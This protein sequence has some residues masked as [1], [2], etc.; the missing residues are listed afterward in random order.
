AALG[1]GVGP[2]A[3]PLAFAAPLFLSATLLFLV[4]P[5][6]AKMVLPLLGGAPAVWNTCMV[7]YQAALLLGYAYAHFSTAWLGV[8]RQAFLHLGLLLVPFLVLPIAVARDWVPPGDANPLP[9]L[10]ALLAV[11]VGLPSVV[12]SP[13]APLLQ[14]WFASPGP[15]SARDPYFLYA[16]SN[17]GSMLAL[18]S[19]PALIEPRLRLAD[20]SALWTVT[21]AVLAVLTLACACLL[22]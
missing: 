1:K 8:R 4:Q 5:M 11:S 6:F 20:Q 12:V 17:L 13:S 19:Y 9:W 10:L 15:P 21:Y 2:P 14:K 22:W 7:F 3:R 18:F 16:A